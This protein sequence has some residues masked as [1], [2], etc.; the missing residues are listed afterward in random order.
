MKNTKM[1]AFEY[2]VVLLAI[3]EA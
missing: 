1:A 2:S 3:I